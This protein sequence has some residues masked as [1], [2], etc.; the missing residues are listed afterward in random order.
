MNKYIYV[1]RLL[2]G[3]YVKQ[4]SFNLD[5]NSDDIVLEVVPNVLDALQFTS[6]DLASSCCGVLHDYGYQSMPMGFSS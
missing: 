1:I 6:K 2:N 5:V 3:R 4:V